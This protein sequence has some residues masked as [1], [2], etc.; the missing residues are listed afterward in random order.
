[1]IKVKFGTCSFCLERQSLG[2]VS[3]GTLAVCIKCGET[4]LVPDPRLMGRR[5]FLRRLAGIGGLLLGAGLVTAAL[6]SAVGVKSL[7]DR[8]FRVLSPSQ[9]PPKFSAG[10]VKNPGLAYVFR[11][12]SKGWRLQEGDGGDRTA[13]FVLVSAERKA[14]LALTVVEVSP[15]A[16]LADLRRASE[17]MSS[18]DMRRF[19]PVAAGRALNV[20]DF[21]FVRQGGREI[22][23]F[24]FRLTGPSPGG[25]DL[26]GRGFLFPLNERWYWFTL[27]APSDCLPQAAAEARRLLLG[28][29]PE[30]AE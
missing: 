24:S 3:P 2:G 6:T 15:G 12:P 10:D 16:D 14:R 25:R 28:F 20:L 13:Q 23:E 4:F 17:T 1:M 7:A 11:L 8:S 18:A 5:G 19:L 29:R 26:P 30:P 22:L 27:S 9:S 21:S